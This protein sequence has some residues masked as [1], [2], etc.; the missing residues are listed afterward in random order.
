MLL[1]ALSTTLGDSPLRKNR[2][3]ERETRDAERG[4]AP[5]EARTNAALTNNCTKIALASD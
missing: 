2:E 3:R 5:S 1:S 4:E